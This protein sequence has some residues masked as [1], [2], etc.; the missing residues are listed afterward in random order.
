MTGC[1]RTYEGSQ[2]PGLFS[3]HLQM[4]FDEAVRYPLIEWHDTTVDAETDGRDPR[5]CK[6]CLTDKGSDQS[7]LTWA[8][9]IEHAQFACTSMTPYCKL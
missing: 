5:Y 9:W 3:H 4:Q 2:G 8:E 6:G 1:L 7:V